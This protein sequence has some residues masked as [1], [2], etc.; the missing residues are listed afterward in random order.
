[1]VYIY[2]CIYIFFILAPGPFCNPEKVYDGHIR[3]PDCGP[4]L[5][6]HGL[7]FGSWEA[8][9]RRLQPDHKAVAFSRATGR[10]ADP[11]DATGERLSPQDGFTYRPVP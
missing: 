2:I 9:C 5:R 1:M 7:D 11:H 10:A 4:I 6:A 3:I 8:A